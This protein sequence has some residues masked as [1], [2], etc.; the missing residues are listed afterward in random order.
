MKK[1]QESLGRRKSGAVRLSC[2]PESSD[3][4]VTR[5]REYY[6]IALHHLGYVCFLFLLLISS[7]SILRA[8]S[9]A[10]RSPVGSRAVYMHTAF[11]IGGYPAVSGLYIIRKRS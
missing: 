6:G 3:D 4:T 2:G 5:I 8:L 1:K 7:G 10:F 11:L 9:T